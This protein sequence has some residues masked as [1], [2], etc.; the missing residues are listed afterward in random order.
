MRKRGACLAIAALSVI[1]FAAPPA[2]S[3]ALRIGPFHLGVGLGHRHH[4]HHG[5][6]SARGNAKEARRN[7]PRQVEA[8]QQTAH[9]ATWA[10]LYPSRAMPT[11]FQNVFWPA[12]S[13]PWPFG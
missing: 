10:L 6:P 3:Y 4:H 12:F 2:P 9:Q 1:S 7:E 5:H 13:S 11:I 8:P